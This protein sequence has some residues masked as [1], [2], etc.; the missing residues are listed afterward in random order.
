MV[1]LEKYFDVDV[2]RPIKSAIKTNQKISIDNKRLLNHNQVGYV[3]INAFVSTY[4]YSTVCSFQEISSR[5]TFSHGSHIRSIIIAQT[6]YCEIQILSNQVIKYR[7]QSRYYCLKQLVREMQSRQKLQ[8]L[9][10]ILH[11]PKAINI[12]TIISFDSSHKTKSCFHKQE[13]FQQLEYSSGKLML[14]SIKAKNKEMHIN[15]L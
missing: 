5:S 4:Q 10:H 9:Q 6:S 11:F 12:M 2:T 1:F 7:L 8:V 3:F 14:F 15:A 13:L